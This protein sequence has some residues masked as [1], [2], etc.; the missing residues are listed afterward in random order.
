MVLVDVP[1]SSPLDQPFPQT[2]HHRDGDQY[3][4]YSNHRFIYGESMSPPQPFSMEWTNPNEHDKEASGS[5]SWSAAL[6]ASNS[7]MYAG[8]DLGDSSVPQSSNGSGSVSGMYMT[9]WDTGSMDA[10][11]QRGSLT[12]SHVAPAS[13]SGSFAGESSMGSVDISTT[14]S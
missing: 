14:G 1:H 12:E 3:D 8:S 4:Q 10:G 5:T 6:Q 13:L 2:H 9:G 7:M 11:S